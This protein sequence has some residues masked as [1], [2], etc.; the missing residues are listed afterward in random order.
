M[1]IVIYLLVPGSV[2]TTIVP[3]LDYT[4]LDFE[5]VVPGTPA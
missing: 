4:T 5:T 2:L 3:L 1:H